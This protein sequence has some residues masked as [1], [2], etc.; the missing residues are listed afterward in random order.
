MNLAAMSPGRRARSRLRRVAPED[1]KVMQGD[2]LGPERRSGVA[3]LAGAIDL[4]AAEDIRAGRRL[5]DLPA[6]RRRPH[7]GGEPRLRHPSRRRRRVPRHAAREHG[8]G[9]AEG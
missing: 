9:R 3:W 6:A 1:R 4:L 7:A 8:R 2:S 5:P